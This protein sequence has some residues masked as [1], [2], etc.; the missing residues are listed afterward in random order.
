MLED[1]RDVQTYAVSSGFSAPAAAGVKPDGS[2]VQ[3]FA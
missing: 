1:S 2:F 3:G